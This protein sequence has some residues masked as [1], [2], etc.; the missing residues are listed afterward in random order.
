LDT[1]KFIYEIIFVDDA[2]RDKTPQ[3]IRQ[4]CRRL[5]P[6]RA[7]FHKVNQGRG[8]TVA[9]GIMLARGTVVGYIDI[10]CEVSPVYIPFMVSFILKRKADV[11]VGKRYYRT[12]AGSLL[13]EA[14]SRGYQW[15]SGVLL[16]TGGMDTETGY[17]FFNRKKIVPILRQTEHTGWFWD[18]EIMVRAQRAGLRIMEV[19]VLFMRRFDKK[20]SVHALRDSMTYLVNLWKFRG[21]QL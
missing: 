20:S 8:K 5:P 2:S 10:D 6:Y 3:L 14:M 15:I 12:S 16:G 21:T 9:D 17:K 19:P 13:R 4:M 7:I 11:I 18:T 1:G